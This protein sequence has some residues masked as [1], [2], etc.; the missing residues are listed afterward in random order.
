MRWQPAVR[1][2]PPYH[3][4]P[5]YIAALATSLWAALTRLP[6]PAG[7]GARLVSRAAARISSTRAIRTF[8]N[9]R[10]RRGSCARRLGWPQEKL[11]IVF[12]S[13]FGKAEWLQPYAD[14]TIAGLAK[15]GVK[16]LAVVMPGFS[17]DCLETLEEIAIRAAETFKEN[18]GEDFAA[19]PCLNDSAEGMALIETLVRRELSGWV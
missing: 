2:L 18:G 5:A 9:A 13:R 14:E 15:S 4:D 12:Q 11:R 17:A 3:D 6:F 16:R 10:R 19:I 7:G 1:T 8:A